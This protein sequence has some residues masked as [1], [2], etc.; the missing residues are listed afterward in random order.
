MSS[1]K[2]SENNV[3]ALNEFFEKKT[4]KTH[5]DEIRTQFDSFLANEKKLTAE[6]IDSSMRAIGI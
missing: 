5:M 4:G 6:R 3:S 2:K 1:I